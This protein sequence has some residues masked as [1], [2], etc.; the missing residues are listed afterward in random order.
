[1][2]RIEDYEFGKVTVDGNEQRQDLIVLPGRVVSNWRRKDG[3]SLVVE[4]LG[5]VLEDL[6][7]LLIL[8]TG[9]DGQMRPKPQTIDELRERG[10]QVEVMPTGEAVARYGDL[11]PER[12]AAA[13]HLTC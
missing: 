7:E 12:T 2:S 6:P 4:D 9:H 8:G 10:I 1:M 11:D 3:H 5:E 13:L